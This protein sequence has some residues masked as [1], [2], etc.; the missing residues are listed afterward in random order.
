M[1]WSYIRNHI[2]PIKNW[3]FYSVWCKCLLVAK[4][5]HIVTHIDILCTTFQWPTP[6]L[7]ELVGW[8][9]LNPPWHQATR[10]QMPW[11]KMCLWRK[12]VNPAWMEGKTYLCFITLGKDIAYLT[13]S[14][15]ISSTFFM[16]I[17]K[18][19][20]IPYIAI[21]EKWEKTTLQ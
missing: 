5:P 7:V 2:H 19:C 1:Y 14:G 10:D 17:G 13:V 11:R 8:V 6:S 21:Y 15:K 12:M 9:L 4:S 3:S 18:I 20:C 16:V